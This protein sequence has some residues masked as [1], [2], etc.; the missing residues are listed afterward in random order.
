MTAERRFKT[1]AP[2]DWISVPRYIAGRKPFVHSDTP[3]VDP[4][5]RLHTF[6]HAVRG[7]WHMMGV[8]LSAGGCLQWFR[9]TLCQAEIKAAKKQKIDP[10]EILTEEARRVS[11]GSQGLFFLPY[12]SGERTP[13]ADPD[14]RACFVGLT[15]AHGRGDMTRSVM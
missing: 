7:K 14:A 13:H 2:F 5:G 11:P 1:G 8:N 3:E 9:N 15:L 10:Y 6:C 12:L 4:H